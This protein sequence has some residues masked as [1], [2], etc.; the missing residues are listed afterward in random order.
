[1]SK[2]ALTTLCLVVLPCVGIAG[3]VTAEQALARHRAATSIGSDPCRTQTDEEA[4]EEIVVCGRRD[5]P[6][7]LPLYEPIVGDDGVT[8]R[9]REDAIDVVRDAVAPC[10]ARGEAC[11]KPLPIIG[12]SFGPGKKGGIV[13]G[14]DRGGGKDD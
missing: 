3:P 2:I 8:G 6:Y 5:S 12:M 1:M 10:H 4:D 14:Q 11:L 7:S 9:E 13:I